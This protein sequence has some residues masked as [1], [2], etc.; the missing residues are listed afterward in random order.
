M[1][2]G[3]ILTATDGN[4]LYYKFIPIFIKAWQ[5]LL[6]HASVHI[7]F[8]ADELPPEIAPY[9]KHV[10]LVK[11]LAGLHTAF[12][13]QCI[14]LLFPRFLPTTDGVLISDMDMLP[15]NRSYYEDAIL[16]I[17]NDHFVTYRDVC[18]PTEIAMCYNIATPSVWASVFEGDPETLMRQWYTRS[19][20]DGNHG[21][22]GWNT[23]QLVLIDAFN[24]W[25]G[26]KMTLNDRLTGYNRLDR[27]HPHAFAD[28]SALRGR[29]HRG[30]Y[31]DYHCLRPYDDF[32]EVNDFVVESLPKYV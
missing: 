28:P 31:S 1:R 5:T 25:K 6:P 27:I 18:L 11:P 9:S 24:A 17:P 10:H 23:D 20:Y 4:P 13:A 3:S 32:K 29:I 21:G 16:S 30:E 15:M 22:V 7:A 12:Q 2:V 26:P 19:P 8:V 14:R